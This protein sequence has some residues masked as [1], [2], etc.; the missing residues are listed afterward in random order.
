MYLMGK[1]GFKYRIWNFNSK[2]NKKMSVDL[3]KLVKCC[4]LLKNNYL[5]LKI[6]FFIVQLLLLTDYFS[7]RS[8]NY[9]YRSN[10]NIPKITWEFQ[11]A[12][13]FH[14]RLIFQIFYLYLYLF[15]CYHI[16]QSFTIL[17]KPREIKC[18]S[19]STATKSI[20]PNTV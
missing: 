15:N 16:F 8:F 18:T 7:Y 5:L 13:L 12:E 17:I 11:S 6:L 9:S 4:L 3:V 20:L 19:L 1:A 10:N 14:Y 2:N